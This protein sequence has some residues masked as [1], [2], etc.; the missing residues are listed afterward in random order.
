[1]NVVLEHARVAHGEVVRAAALAFRDGRVADDARDAYRIDLSDHII[2]P[3]LINAHDHLQLNGIPP[4][5]HATPF[6]SSYEWIDAMGAHR[7]RPEVIAAVSAPSDDRH[8]QGALKNLLAGTTTVAHHDPWDSV[9]DDADFPV[10][11]LREYGWSHSLGLGAPS[12]DATLYG[13]AVRESFCATPS[14]HPWIIHLAEGVDARAA[15]ELSRLDALGCLASNTVLVHGVGLTT[16]DIA[17]IIERRASVVWCPASNVELFRRTLAPRC[18][19]EAGRLA[20][21]T[22]SRLTGARDLLEEL[23]VAAANSDLSPR[24]LFALVTDRAA[25][26][27]RLDDRGGLDAGQ[28]ADCVIIRATMDPYASLIGTSRRD[29]RAVVRGGMPA[30]ADQD[31]APWF[32]R[33][34]LDT[35]AVTV[36]GAP[37]LL[38][39]RFARAGAIALEPGLELA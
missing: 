28:Q 26:V 39:R 34:G 17:R 24:E 1:M 2:L 15:E 20:L 25:D 4:L 35:V 18:L 5:Q 21:G 13:P 32:A 30:V 29:I 37:K 14:S 31:F 36:D 9:F 23:R 12:R 6:A 33:C 22:D 27:L 8:W 38:A 16:G 10:T 3:G 19:H 7:R 11:V